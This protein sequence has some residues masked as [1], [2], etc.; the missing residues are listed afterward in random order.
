MSQDVTE[1]APAVFNM[2]FDNSGLVDGISYGGFVL[3]MYFLF[4]DAPHMFVV[5]LVDAI[6]MMQAFKFAGKKWHDMNVQNTEERKKINSISDF[7]KAG[8]KIVALGCFV[9]FSVA[10][11]L[12]MK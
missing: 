6:V 9:S 11:I 3:S 10:V 2:A 7:K 1:Q 8:E 12:L 5:A 4:M